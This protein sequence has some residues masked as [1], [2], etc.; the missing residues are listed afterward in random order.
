MLECK[1]EIG[2]RLQ[3]T[4]K[5]LGYLI[6]HEAFYDASVNSSCLLRRT[7]GDS[8]FREGA[9]HHTLQSTSQGPEARGVNHVSITSPMT[10]PDTDVGAWLAPPSCPLL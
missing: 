5:Y 10:K 9:L 1:Q 4:G 6:M 7:G 8:H 2:R 3:G